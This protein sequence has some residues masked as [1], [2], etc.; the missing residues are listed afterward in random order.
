MIRIAVREEKASIRKYRAQARWIGDR[1][2][3]E[4]LRRIIQDEEQHLVVLGQLYETLC[5]HGGGRSQVRS[6]PWRY[7][8]P[9]Y[10]SRAS[11]VRSRRRT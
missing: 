11:V 10:H 8:S 4:N 2:I 1:N 9:R 6:S 5:R 7:V 3:V